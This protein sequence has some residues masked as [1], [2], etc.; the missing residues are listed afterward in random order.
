VSAAS[1]LYDRG[2]I[3]Q[4]REEDTSAIL[5]Y[6]AAL[7]MDE[8]L[9]IAYLQLSTVY[10]GRGEL[11]EAQRWLETAV[12]QA[13]A[14]ELKASSAY[15]R[16]GLI[17]EQ[18]N[19]PAEARQA[20]QHAI[21]LGPNVDRYY[22]LYARFLESQG[23]MDAALFNLQTMAEKGYQK[24]WAYEQLGHF[25][26]RRELYDDALLAFQTA[27][28][29]ESDD[30]LLYTY[31]ADV[32]HALG[33]TDAA[34]TASQQAVALNETHGIYFVY[35]KYAKL[36]FE[37]G[38]YEQ[39]SEYYEKSLALRPIDYPVLMTLGVAQELIGNTAYAAELYQRI[40]DYSDQFDDEQVQT[41][42]ERL[43]QLQQSIP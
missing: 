7:S 20:Y 21:Q 30:P 2:I 23:E 6:K 38:D 22:F 12:S 18:Q 13:N 14:L 8:T 9:Y 40:I 10:Q 5:D 37:L 35:A 19:R 4:V 27:V 17:F 16:L 15:L 1:A 3:H 41:A 42:V 26:F 36:L 24:G 28:N 31:L 43:Q 34:L 33:N 11:A 39:A 29:Y 32:H 25:Y